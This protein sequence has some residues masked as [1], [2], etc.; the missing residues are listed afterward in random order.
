VGE[1]LFLRL[2]SPPRG[3]G[4]NLHCCF[5]SARAKFGVSQGF[6]MFKSQVRDFLTPANAPE[7]EAEFGGRTN[8][9]PP[10]FLRL[11]RINAA[12][13]NQRNISSRSK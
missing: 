9:H 5:F 4:A 13:R 8:P 7:I 12:E 2:G 1:S 6:K 11:S 3:A 10:L